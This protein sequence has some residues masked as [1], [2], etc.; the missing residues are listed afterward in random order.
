MS[1]NSK[2]NSS[3]ISNTNIQPPPQPRQQPLSSSR[4]IPS[5]K[6][7]LQ[8]TDTTSTQVQLILPETDHPQVPPITL[9]Q[10]HSQQHAD[11]HQSHFLQQRYTHYS[12]G[13]QSLRDKEN[14]H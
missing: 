14:V 6:S 3:V 8:R 10:P 9:N 1:Q 11:K 7:S 4:D 2:H 12:Q 13:P 5:R